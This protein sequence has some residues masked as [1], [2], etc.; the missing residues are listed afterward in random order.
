MNIK[1]SN[2]FLGT[3]IVYDCYDFTREDIYMIW[4]FLWGYPETC[5]RIYENVWIGDPPD[6]KKA[7]GC[8]CSCCKPG[9]HYHC[10]MIIHKSQSFDN[11]KTFFQARAKIYL[12]V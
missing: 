4:Y 9:K 7:P 2:V 8:K 10:A 5:T 6:F 12:Y 1:F 11:L 3:D